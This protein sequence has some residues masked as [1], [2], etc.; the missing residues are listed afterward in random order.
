MQKRMFRHHSAIV[1]QWLAVPF[2]YIGS[3]FVLLLVLVFFFILF[4]PYGG[5]VTI[6]SD[7]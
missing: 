7:S 3:T 6:A 1:P 5:V 4:I 2:L